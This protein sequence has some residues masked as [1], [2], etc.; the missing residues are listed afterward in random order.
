MESSRRIRSAL[1]PLLLLLAPVSAF[2]PAQESPEKRIERHFKTAQQ[3]FEQEEYDRAESEYLTIL[4]IALDQLGATYSALTDYGKAG[5]AYEQ[6][7]RSTIVNIQPYLGLGI[8]YLR[9][10]RLEEGK[11]LLNKILEIN[12]TNPEVKHLLGKYHYMEGD[13]RAAT[14]ELRDALTADPENI[15]IAYTLGVAYLQRKDKK[16]ADEVFGLMLEQLGESA[17]LHVLLG[18]AYRQTEYWNEALAEFQKAADLDPDYPR[19]HYNI[20]LTYVLW[21]GAGAYDRAEKELR[22]ELGNHPD[23]YLPNF[24]LGMILSMRHETEALDYL[25][26]A[27]KLSPENPDPYLYLGQ[28]YFRNSQYKEAVQVLNRSI[29]LTRNPARNKYQLS[30]VHFILGQSLI[31]L[32]RREEARIHM[33]KAQEF[34]RLQSRAARENFER[35]TADSGSDS[36]MT[37]NRFRNVHSSETTVIL[38]DPPPDEETRRRLESNAVFFRSAAANAYQGLARLKAEQKDFEKAAELLEYASSWD[39]SLPDLSFNLGLAY[40]KAGRPEKAAA[41]F[42][43]ALKNNPNREDL[44]KLLQQLSLQLVREKKPDPALVAL[45]AI[46][47]F[48]ARAA[49]FYVLRGQAYAQKGNYD[50]ALGD[51]RQALALNPKLDEVHYYSGMSLIR[52]GRLAEALEEFDRELNRHP[53]HAKALY[54]KAF[55]LITEH[56]MEEAIPLLLEVIRL[57]SKYSEA[58]YQLGKIQ[59]EKNQLLLAAANLETSISLNPGASH[60]YYLLSRAYNRLGRIEEAKQAI[61]RYRELKKIEE[62]I[63]DGKIPPAG[64]KPE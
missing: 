15:G 25:L 49:E 40:V 34:K 54:H 64:Q 17:A 39:D 12:P 28:I 31:R 55:V 48:F 41:P 7:C 13:F 50:R 16:K 4:G 9:T 35:Q 36:G 56:R 18:R 6:A 62:A 11:Q 43:A 22:I 27:V 47:P 33:E 42:V 53:G 21:E 10:G 61:K 30:D 3:A 59:L 44:R 63:R 58:Y 19:V 5:S 2:L 29:E 37:I 52:Q 1:M 57:D 24:Y 23:L 60:H 14:R 45:E 32:G 46:A 8:I 38:R 20:G 26:K 51:F